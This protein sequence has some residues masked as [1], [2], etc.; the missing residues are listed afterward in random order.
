VVLVIMAFVFVG[1]GWSE[2]DDLYALRHRGE[3][4]TGTVVDRYGGK[5]EHLVVE[6]VTRGG[7]KVQADTT[8]FFD[9]E[10]G[11][12]IEVIYDRDHPQLMQTTDYGLD[13]GLPAGLYGL[14]AVGFAVGG[15]VKLRS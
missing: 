12:P 8:H 11:Q 9:A 5:T 4:V 14:V 1:V 6:F 13:Y 2:V 15:I 7:A 3:V 10:V